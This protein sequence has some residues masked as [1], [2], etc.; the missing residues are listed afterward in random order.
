MV[1][2]GVGFVEGSVDGTGDGG[3]VGFADGRGIGTRDGAGDGSA[4][5]E[6]LASKLGRGLALVRVLK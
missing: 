3:S 1:G 2:S 4:T 6:E 5:E